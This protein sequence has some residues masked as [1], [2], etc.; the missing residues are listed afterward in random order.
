[1][2]FG[3]LRINESIKRQL[4][5][6]IDSGTLSHAILL[7][8]GSEK[9]RKAL[10]LH[11][12]EALLCEGKDKPC[13][14]CRSC[15]KIKAGTHP[16]VFIIS[17]E[18]GKQRSIKIDDVREIRQKAYILPNEAPF[19]IFII[20]EAS[21]MGEEAQNALLKILE[22][23]PEASRFILASR[24]RDDLRQTIL[25]RVT[26]FSVSEESAE[27]E[28]PKALSAAEN[29]LKATAERDEYKIIM[30][31]GALEKNRKLFKSSLEIMITLL[32]GAAASRYRR[33]DDGDETKKKLA[34]AFTDA[35]LIEMQNFLKALIADCDKNANENLLLTNL[36][37]GLIC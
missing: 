33:T 34:Q 35:Q 17:G 32:S 23:P 7:T 16:D 26:A 36:A 24:S 37:T 5:S 6:A 15:L 3:R 12:A 20:L 27:K 9:D 10:A 13:M 25:S 8:G 1:M 19:Q 28:N 29:I 21:C 14:K 11:I 31:S 18:A 2:N 22:E 30:A 4:S